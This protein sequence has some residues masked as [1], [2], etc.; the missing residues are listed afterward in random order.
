MSKLR[1]SNFPNSHADSRNDLGYGRSSLQFSKPRS[2]GQE[3][4][5]IKV[6][7]LD[8]EVDEEDIEMVSDKMRVPRDYDPSAYADPFYYVA[9]NTKLSEMRAST[10]I[11]PFP[12]L[13]SKR[14]GHIGSKT[15]PYQSHQYGFKQDGLEVDTSMDWASYSRNEENEEDIYNLEDVAEKTL[16]EYVRM[17]LMEYYAKVK[18]NS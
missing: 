13:Y 3:F 9:G 15:G 4:P 1:V 8:A 2:S 14:D 11:S 5:Y 18:C 7:L 16:R 17:Q 10:S 6:E 12:S